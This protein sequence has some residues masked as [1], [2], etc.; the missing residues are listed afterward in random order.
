MTTMDREKEA[1]S[2]LM[3]GESQELEL[4][5]S[6]DSI[7]EHDGLRAWW[8]RQQQVS[9]ILQSQRS[10]QTGVDVSARVRSTLAS[11]PQFQRN[12]L[13]SMAIAASVTLAVVMG[14]QTLVP[15][16]DLT[17]E[18]LVS[19]IGGA[20]VPVMGA[21]PIRASF[22]ARP[23]QPA[24]TQQPHG[25]GAAARQAAA[26]YERLARDRYLRLG[27]QHARAAALNHPAPFVHSTRTQVEPP[28]EVQD[29]K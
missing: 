29:S 2:A 6:L 22:D 1:L 21:Q 24:S 4:R 26:A 23:E 25:Q 16:A 10:S 20:V 27:E 7:G 9:E 3:D 11:Q 5:R 17:P 28:P 12:P 8:S 14:G 19:D 18:P 13:W 15:T